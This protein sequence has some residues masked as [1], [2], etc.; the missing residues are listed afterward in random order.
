MCLAVPMQ[1]VTRE[2][3]QARCAARGAERLVSL[4]LLDPEDIA[5]GDY[6]MVHAGRAIQKMT[7][8]EAAS[9]WALYDEMFAALAPPAA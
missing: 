1:V 9:A 6:L 3:F 8:A 2:G 7:E 5:A 4:I